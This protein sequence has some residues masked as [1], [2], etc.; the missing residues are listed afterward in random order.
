M[1]IESDTRF[2]N[3]A[4]ESYSKSAV[5]DET[6]Y[7]CTLD[8]TRKL[9]KPSDSILELGC[10]TGT[11]ALHLADAVRRYLATDLSPEMIKIAETKHTA[12]NG[13]P[14]P[15]LSFR[16]ATAES[17]E[18]S[19]NSELEG[20]LLHFDAILGFNYL[21]LVHDLPATLRRV[22]ALLADGG[23]FISKTP[24]VGEMNIVLRLGLPVMQFVSKAPHVIV[25]RE[26]EL[27]EQIRAAG[28]EIL[29]TEMHATKGNDHRPY[30]IARK[31]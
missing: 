2:W 25:F 24:C 26:A 14:V 4:A 1:G 13:G 21:H 27:G 10:G 16:T 29:R 22:H 11:T 5:S 7:Q 31:K 6:A 30:I 20:N 17:L 12:R 3:R 23:L 28:F 8:E 18:D 9:L 15:G 19:P